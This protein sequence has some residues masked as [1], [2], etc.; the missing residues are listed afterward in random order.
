MVE[1]DAAV[2]RVSSGNGIRIDKREVDECDDAV[3]RS[4]VA[5]NLFI[6]SLTN[7]QTPLIIE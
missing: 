7:S 5:R 4:V 6:Q 1:T 2:V 3:G